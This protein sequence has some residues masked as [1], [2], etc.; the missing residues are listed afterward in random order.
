[1]AFD[2]SLANR[3]R[4]TLAQKKNIEGF[5][6]PQIHIRFDGRSV[7]VEQADLDVGE[8]STDDQIRQAVANHLGVSEA[9]LQVFAIYRNR[10]TG[11]MTLRPEAMSP[12]K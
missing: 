7:D 1:M 5:A 2:E 3:I 9:K 11:S 12:G 6:S 10:Q 8:T 4:R